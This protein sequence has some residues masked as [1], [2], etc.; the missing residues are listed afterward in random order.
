MNISW[1]PAVDPA[2]F[3]AT[4]LL[5]QKLPLGYY[6]QFVCNLIVGWKGTT[7]TRAA[8]CCPASGFFSSRI[9]S[10]WSRA[11]LVAR[12]TNKSILCWSIWRI[13]CTKTCPVCKAVY[14]APVM[15]PR[16]DFNP[17]VSEEIIPGDL[18]RRRDTGEVKG[19]ESGVASPSYHISSLV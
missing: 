8:V 17:D 19:E 2:E 16:T 9:S 5:N 4:P 15:A 6:L 18:G 14:C 12:V 11:S 13:R 3:L 7:N 10:T 1:C